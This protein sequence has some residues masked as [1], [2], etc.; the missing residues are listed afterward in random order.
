MISAGQVASQQAKWR[1]V[2]PNYKRGYKMILYKGSFPNVLNILRNRFK[3]S[4]TLDLIM[5]VRFLDR[6]CLHSPSC[7]GPCDNRRCNCNTARRVCCRNRRRSRRRAGTWRRATR[8]IVHIRICSPRIRPS[9][10]R[11]SSCRGHGSC[12]RAP[13][14]KGGHRGMN[15]AATGAI[16]TY[17]C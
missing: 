14:C 2:D 12:G 13:G 6:L 8:L 5:Q 9:N 11:T 1:I 4:Q 7:F 15:K 10:R 16:W 3:D 17:A